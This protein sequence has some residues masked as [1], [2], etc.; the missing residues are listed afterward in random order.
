M[1]PST[2][3]PKQEIIDILEKY[4]S[5]QKSAHAIAVRWV[6]AQGVGYTG[7]GTVKIDLAR[8]KVTFLAI[9][10]S[11]GMGLA[12]SYPLR[13]LW[14]DTGLTEAAK[15]QYKLY[16]ETREALCKERD[17]INKLDTRIRLAEIQNQLNSSTLDNPHGN[18]V[19]FQMTPNCGFF[20]FQQFV[21]P[22]NFH[23]YGT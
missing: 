16:Q 21:P 15:A 20:D 22:A 17:E 19:N 9:P 14:D 10:S 23:Y 6:Q 8:D 18:A 7:A 12:A 3:M 1:E 4:E 5:V 13:F 11:S 2:N